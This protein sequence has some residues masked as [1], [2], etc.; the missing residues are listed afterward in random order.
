MQCPENAL[1]ISACVSTPGNDYCAG[2]VCRA[3]RAR[4]AKRNIDCGI[5]ECATLADAVRQEAGTVDTLR[6]VTQMATYAQHKAKMARV[7]A[8]RLKQ[9]GVK[10]AQNGDAING[11]DC[12][13]QELGSTIGFVCTKVDS[14]TNST[15]VC[16]GTHAQIRYSA[17]RSQEYT[18]DATR[19]AGNIPA[20]FAGNF[21][22]VLMEPD[23][24]YF[25]DNRTHK[26]WLMDK[27]VLPRLVTKQVHC[28]AG[29]VGATTCDVKKI[30]ACWA[31]TE[32]LEQSTDPYKRRTMFNLEA[33]GSG[34]GDTAVCPPEVSPEEKQ[35]LMH[36]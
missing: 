8:S 3:C 10:S 1:P 29:A 28:T 15:T 21:A 9:E 14:A 19:A 25:T 2:Q 34:Q 30:N 11:F 32:Q 20:D 23:P 27:I 26:E 18:S 5:P 7:L 33:T 6:P 36:Y 4:L 16:K 22:R 31:P 17:C 24:I 35:F 13:I 12:S